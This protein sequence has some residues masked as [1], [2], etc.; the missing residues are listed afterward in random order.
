MSNTCNVSFNYTN[1]NREIAGIVVA[2]ASNLTAPSL[3]DPADFEQVIAAKNLNSGQ[4]AQGFSSIATGLDSDY[5]AIAL[6]FADDPSTTYVLTTMDGPNPMVP[7]IC[8]NVKE[9]SSGPATFNL[10]TTKTSPTVDGFFHVSTNEVSNAPALL[11]NST[12][13]DTIDIINAVVDMLQN[14]VSKG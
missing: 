7:F 4:S 13:V 3:L 6:A 8:A 1:G 10:D 9:D 12:L 14:I 2:H 5:W 11:Q